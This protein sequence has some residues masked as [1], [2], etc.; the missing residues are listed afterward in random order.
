MSTSLNETLIAL[1]GV[2]YGSQFMRSKF[3]YDTNSNVLY[4]G[5]APRGSL[6]SEARWVVHKFVYSAAGDLTD[7]LP[8][9]PNQIYDNYLT[10]SYLN[11]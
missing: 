3:V 6:T 5:L 10:L 11:V 9:A 4:T 1:K 8:S 7:I 2:E